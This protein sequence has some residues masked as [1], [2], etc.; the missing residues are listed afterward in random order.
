MEKH[1]KVLVDEDGDLER[2]DKY[3]ALILPEQSRTYIQALIK[4]GHVLISGAKTKSHHKIRAG[5]E[6]EVNLPEPIAL[7]IEPEDIPLEVLHEDGSII[8]V[9]KGAGMVV[10]PAAG[11]YSHTLVNAL[12]FRTKDLSDINGVLR[13]GIVHRLD[14]DTS[15]CIVV[16]KTNEAHRKISAQ[17]EHRETRKE[18]IAIVRG[19]IKD[20]HGFIDVAIARH[21]VLRKK[22][23]ATPEGRTALTRYEVVERFSNATILRIKP[24]T[25]RTHQIRVHLS[26]LGYPILGDEQYA[27]PHRS[28]FAFPIPRQML[29]AMTLGITHPETGHFIEFTAPLPDDMEFVIGELRK[30]KIR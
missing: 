8:V 27:R 23:A 5:D 12:M 6:I 24:E 11:N 30:E 17:F 3:L 19:V 7:D 18:Y 25:G 13:P 14:K 29:H 26:H 20:N 16:A 10:H 28:Q 9:N 15:G 1:I 21:P 2:L 22:M 4:E